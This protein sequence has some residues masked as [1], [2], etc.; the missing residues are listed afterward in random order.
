MVIYYNNFPLKVIVKPNRIEQNLK[1]L[2]YVYPIHVKSSFHLVA[3]KQVD[4]LR[5]YYNIVTIDESGFSSFIPP[6]NAI[7]ILHPSMSNLQRAKQNL[8]E[9]YT[10]IIGFDVCDSDR[11]SDLAVS[12]INKLDKVGVSSEY[13]VKVYRESG[14]KAKTYHIPHG[15]DIEYY[16]KPNLWQ[17]KQNVN[18]DP[19]LLNIYNYKKS[20]GKKILLFWLWHS[21][22]RK[23]FP[24][25]AEVYKRLREKRND[26]ILVVKTTVSCKAI[27]ELKNLEFIKL[28]TWLDDNNKMALYDLSDIVLNSSRGGGFEINCLESLARGIPCISSNVGSWVEYEHPS[29]LVKTDKKVIVLPNN[30]YHSGYGYTIDIED[31]VAKIED[32]IDHYNEYKEIAEE[33]RQKLKESYEWGKIAEK[34]YKMIEE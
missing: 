22:D 30:G 15:V 10:Q 19:Q 3:E 16:T 31:T 26:I 14:V 34:I 25:V 7:L 11:L 21:P 13:C 29:F 6:K 24:E 23:G 28:T 5:K 1:L 32:M 4:H 18:I 9:Q 8:K 20:S 33:H 12:L 17:S 2:Y 27:K